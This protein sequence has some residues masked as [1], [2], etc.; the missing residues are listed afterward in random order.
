MFIIKYK[1][2]D[3]AKMNDWKRFE[4]KNPSIAVNIL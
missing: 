2:E 1:W 3:P 4:E